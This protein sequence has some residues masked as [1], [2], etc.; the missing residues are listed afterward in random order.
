M[1][2]RGTRNHPGK[3]DLLVLDFLWHTTRLDLCHPAS[4]IADKPEVAKRMTEI[5]EK[6]AG[7]PDAEQLD[8]NLLEET[9]ENEVQKEREEALARELKANQRKASRTVDPLEFAL[10]LHDSDLEEYEPIM[11]W[12]EAPASQKQLDTLARFGF[13]AARIPNRGFASMLLDKI[14][15]RSRE[16]LATPKQIKLLER[17]GY[18]DA[19]ELAF[20][21][22]KKLIDA[23]ASNGWRRPQ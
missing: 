2:G 17:Y 16:N 20:P 18:K 13:D 21:D 3:D 11:P 1:I 10:S 14:I 7:D 12:Q 8:L 23:L 5:Q 6:A 15:R 22:A 9:A 19:G 4:L